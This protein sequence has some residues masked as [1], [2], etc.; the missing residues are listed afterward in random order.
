MNLRSYFFHLCFL[1]SLLNPVLTHADQPI[2]EGDRPVFAV[3]YRGYVK[4]GFEEQ[5]VDCWRTVAS[6]FVEERGALGSTLHKT[7][8]GMMVAYSR[9]PDKAARDSSWPRDNN[10][11]NS[12]FPADV[13]DAI[14]GLK[15]CID[16]TRRLPE[17]CM[18]IVEVVVPSLSPAIFD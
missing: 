8:D 10:A 4:P 11:I 2:I 14:I 9:W 7:E 1:Y 6:Y 12:A 15:D 13:C 5:Y 17:I 16:S 3:I 18:E